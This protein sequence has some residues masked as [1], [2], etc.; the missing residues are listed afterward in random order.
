MPC[1]RKLSMMDGTTTAFRRFALAVLR[2]GSIYSSTTGTRID[3]SA[4]SDWNLITCRRVW[5]TAGSPQPSLREVSAM[6]RLSIPCLMVVSAD[7]ISSFL[8]CLKHLLRR[9]RTQKFMDRTRDVS[10]LALAYWQLTN[11]AV[12]AETFSGIT[13][14]LSKSALV[15]ATTADSIC[16]LV[17]AGTFSVLMPLRLVSATTSFPCATCLFTSAVAFACTLLGGTMVARICVLRWILPIGTQLAT[18]CGLMLILPCGIHEIYA[19]VG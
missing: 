8:I 9:T 11:L 6:D 4:R 14:C 7:I 2:V 19:S 16:R 15:H 13:T 3:V 1:S 17:S 12:S 5:L 18:I 10:A